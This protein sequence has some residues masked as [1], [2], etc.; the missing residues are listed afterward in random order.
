M[1]KTRLINIIIIVFLFI[2]IVHFFIERMNPEYSDI[3]EAFYESNRTTFIK[4]G[5]CL[6]GLLGLFMLKKQKTAQYLLAIVSIGMMWL[7]ITDG[8][9]NHLLL[10]YSAISLSILGFL[11]IYLM[12][13]SGRKILNK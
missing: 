2:D 12:Y 4:W 10:W 6:L 11:G 1:N 8:P 3:T 9:L 13:F 7:S 5:L